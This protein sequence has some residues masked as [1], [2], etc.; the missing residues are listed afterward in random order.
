MELIEKLIFGK[1]VF[2]KDILAELEEL[3]IQEMDQCR[4]T[5]CPVAARMTTEEWWEAEEGECPCAVKGHK[6]LKFI[7]DREEK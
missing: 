6:M 7:K 1:K 2:K 5:H 3:C 4:E